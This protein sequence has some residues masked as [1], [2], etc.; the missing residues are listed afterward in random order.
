M[1]VQAG[2]WFA[3]ANNIDMWKLFKEVVGFIEQGAAPEPQA[4]SPSAGTAPPGN[5]LHT[6]RPNSCSEGHLQ[7]IRTFSH[8]A[9]TACC[10]IRLL[11]SM[12]H[13]KF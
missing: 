5:I 4:P 10:V 6:V 2:I 1:L 9:L 7:T 11:R 8:A 12:D 13:L 3:W